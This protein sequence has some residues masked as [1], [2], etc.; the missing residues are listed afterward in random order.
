M[1]RSETAADVPGDVANGVGI[2]AKYV[3][4]VLQAGSLFDKVNEL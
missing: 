3:T 1:S 2:G 4:G